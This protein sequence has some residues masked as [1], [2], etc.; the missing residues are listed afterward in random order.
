MWIWTANFFFK[1]SRKKTYLTKVKIFQN[2]LG[3]LLFSETP[4]RFA[5]NNAE[6]N[7]D[8]QMCTPCQDGRKGGECIQV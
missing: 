3:G 5:T 6:A 7:E 2:V 8:G 4:C 1:I